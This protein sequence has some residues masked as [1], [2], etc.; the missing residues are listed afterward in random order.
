M[1][2]LLGILLFLFITILT[3]QAQDFE[4][5]PL[6]H[7]E[8]W[9]KLL[10]TPS[11]FTIWNEYIGR[12]WGKMS[13]EEKTEVIAWRRHLL[14]GKS[15]TKKQSQITGIPTHHVEEAEVIV[16]EVIKVEQL[17]VKEI[18]AL[19]AIMLEEEQEMTQLTTNISSNFIVIEDL[20]DE[21]YKELGQ[22]YVFYSEKHPK[23]KYSK[24]SWV[25]EQEKNIKT[26]K[27]KKYRALRNRIHITN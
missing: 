22:T 20:Y 21:I 9:Q 13:K 17:N 7:P 24:T 6:D 3:I 10:K 12:E 16:Q 4:D 19:E 25:E 5:D 18:R 27:K 1:K 14:A 15:F 23:G 26:I 8:L 11:D 2:K